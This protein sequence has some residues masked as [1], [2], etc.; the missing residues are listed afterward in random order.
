MFDDGQSSADSVIKLRAEI[1]KAAR[2]IT[3]E[4]HTNETSDTLIPIV[5]VLVEGGPSSLETICQAL[6]AN[7]PVVVV[8]VKRNNSLFSYKLLFQLPIG[9]RSCC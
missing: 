1:E 9:F 3:T 4:S 2:Q 5:L 8:K 6:E 7:T